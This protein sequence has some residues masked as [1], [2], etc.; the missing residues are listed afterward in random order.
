VAV[1]RH[2]QVVF[3]VAVVAYLRRA[4]EVVVLLHQV[5][6]LAVEAVC[7]HPTCQIFP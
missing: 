4:V 6:V 3:H 5:T 1:Y 7:H 2:P